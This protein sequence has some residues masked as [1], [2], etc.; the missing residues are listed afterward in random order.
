MVRLVKPLEKKKLGI[1]I[2]ARPGE[3]GFTH[4]LRLAETAFT[5][6]VDVYLYCVDQAV[7]GLDDP[8]LVT[9]RNNGVKLYACAYGAQKLNLVL[10]DKATFA[11]L[12]VISDLI[13][14]TDRFV[15]FN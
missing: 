9:L 3:T 5:Q 10:T 6:G 7:Q 11:G 12:T 14:N 2:S 13:A 15:T 8:R 1:L 4:A